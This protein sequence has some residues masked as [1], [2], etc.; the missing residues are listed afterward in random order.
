MSEPQ[1][2]PQYN[3]QKLPFMKYAGPT[4]PVTEGYV[5]IPPALVIRDETGSTW[6]LGF[7]YSQTEWN[8][9]RFEYDIVRNG[10]VTGEFGRV[11]E[12]RNNSYG[13]KVVRVWGSDGR[14]GA[15]WKIWSGRCF[16]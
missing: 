11:I 10:K 5:S 4:M 12:Y 2:G 1:L 6:T 16:V 9:G 15:G 3:L 13:Q 8:S 7:D 14:G